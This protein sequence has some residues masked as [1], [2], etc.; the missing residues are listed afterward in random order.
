MRARQLEVFCTLMRCGT[1]TGAAAMLNI[2]QPAL[3]QILLHTEDQLGFKLFDRVRGRLVPTQEADELYSQAEHIF[4]ELDALK[5]RTVDMRH[6]R[7]GLVRLAASAPPSMSIVPR[8][9]TAFRE[10]HPE[11]V[12]RSLIASQ[13][14]IVEMLRN[15][16][17][18]LGIAMNNLPHAGIHA[19]TVGRATLVCVVSAG[20]R[21][22]ALDRVRFADISDETLISYRADTLPGRLLAA[23]AEAEDFAYAPAIEID[24]S[25]TA[26]PYVR[27]GLGIAIV[28]SL[29]PWEQFNGVVTRPF[30]PRIEVPVAILTSNDRPLSASHELMRDC[31][32][33]ACRDLKRSSG[34]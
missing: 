7:T 20:H 18:S 33:A 23:S 13:T 3:S 34:T 4:S 24:L 22:A 2:S 27:D 6:G 11:I 8:A 5:R 19:E 25:I 30:E 1:V 32:R 12:V 16:E 10:A 26:L 15:G 17:V 28:D 31:L 29:L 14:A 21:L 9:L